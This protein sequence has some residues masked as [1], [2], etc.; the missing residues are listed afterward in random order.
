VIIEG[1]IK[2]TRELIENILLK[3]LE[4]PKEYANRLSLTKTKPS[5]HIFLIHEIIQ[6]FRKDKF[7]M[8]RPHDLKI[9]MPESLKTIQNYDYELTQ[10]LQSLVRSK[11]IVHSSKL[12]LKRPRG[13]LTKDESEQY[14]ISGTKSYYEASPFLIR[15]ITITDN[16]EARKLIYNSLLKDDILI[17][18]YKKAGLLYPNL[19]IPN[20]IEAVKMIRDSTKLETK[21][22]ESEFEKQ[23]AEDSKKIKPMKKKEIIQK[24]EDWAKIKLNNLTSVDFLWLYPLGASYYIR[25]IISINND[26]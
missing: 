11:L 18:L 19:L 9:R 26:D 3:R 24:N 10:I 13:R 5:K 15:I 23:F 12:P 17:K 7:C 4:S 21:K 2:G 20:N 16:P 14:T 6:I 25:D 1:I 22:T 8:F